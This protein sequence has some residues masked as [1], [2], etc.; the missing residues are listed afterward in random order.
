MK[1]TIA[2]LVLTTVALTGCKAS[3]DT[4]DVKGEDLA[5]QVQAA[6]AKQVGQMPEKVE[7]PDDLNAAEGKT[8][9][10]TLTDS[11]TSYGVTVTSKGVDDDGKV[12]F[13]VEVDQKPQG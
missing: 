10:C 8:V 11:G 1:K 3:V 4:R 13:A 9:R 12:Q 6:L 5:I 2:A 7:C